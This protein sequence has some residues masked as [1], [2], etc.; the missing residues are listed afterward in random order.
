METVLEVRNLTKVIGKRVIIDNLSFSCRA[1]EIYGFL[2]PNGAGKTST[3]KLILGLWAMDGGCIR[4]CGRDLDSEFEQAISHVGSVGDAPSFYESLSGRENLRLTARAWGGIPEERLSAAAEQ[5]G[6]ANR[7][8]DRVKGYSLG[9]KQRLAVARA[10]LPQPKLLLLD[11]P[12]NGLDPAGTRE[13]RELMKDL[14]HRQGICIL[15]S[16]HHMN[17]MELICDR[18]GILGNGRLL[19]EKTLIPAEQAARRAYRFE[20]EPMDKA[21]QV[22]A[23]FPDGTVLSV[24][25]QWLEVLLSGEELE[26]LNRRFLEA[27]VA[28]RTITP[29]KTQV[30]EE[31]F[32]DAAGGGGQLE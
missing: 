2:G 10:L 5:V 32:L 18:A 14:A 4:I 30:L 28:L 20:V 8:D 3:L 17:E 9:M 21:R 15:L 31:L 7:L 13:L 16:S 19:E 26:A 27:G 22:L 29:V 6:L 23:G 24:N 25:A 12:T 11:E 1:G